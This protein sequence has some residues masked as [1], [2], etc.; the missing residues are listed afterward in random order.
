MKKSKSII[1]IAT[2]IA[3][4]IFTLVGCD[5]ETVPVN[6]GQDA[7]VAVFKNGSIDY[8]RQIATTVTSECE[9]R[10]VKPIISYVNDD[11]DA[12]GQF[13]I[14]SGLREL[15]SYYNI[16]GVIIAPVFTK[17]DHRVEKAL[18][19]FAGNDIPVIVIDS[20]IDNDASPLK[21]T[22]KAYV[23]T[24]NA[25]AGAQLANAC[26]VTDASSILAARVAASIPT[27]ARYEGFCKEIGATVPLWETVDLDT[28]ESFSAELAKHPGATNLVFFNGNLCNSVK[29]A[30][31]GVD[32]YTFDVYEQ[33]LLDLKN[34][35]TS[36][37]KGIMAQNTFEMGRQAVTAIFSTTAEKNIYIPTIYIT[38]DNLYSSDVKPFLDY[39]NIREDAK[40]SV[41]MLLGDGNT[42]YWPQI[43]EGAKKEAEVLGVDV[44][45]EFRAAETD[46]QN[47]LKRIDEAGS[48]RNL[49]GIVLA[50]CDIEIDERLASKGL[51]IPIVAIDATPMINSP[52]KDIFAAC[53]VPDNFS[54]GKELAAK[55]AGSKSIV[56]SYAIGGSSDRADGV[57]IGKGAE[58]VQVFKCNTVASAVENLKSCLESNPS[59]YESLILTSGNFVTSEL[60]DIASEAG[61]SVCCVDMNPTIEGYLQSGD[62]LFSAVPDT[63]E[64]G[65][66]AIK[67]I[68]NDKSGYHIHNVTVNYSYPVPEAVDLGLSV[69]WASFNLGATKP[70]GYGDYYAWG[71]TET[72]YEGFAQSG[73]PV[74]KAG[75]DS[76]YDWTTC[77]YCTDGVGEQFSKYVPAGEPSYWGGSGS[78]DNK[79]VL[80]LSDDAAHVKLGGSWRMPTV[81]E[82]I[83]LCEPT[84]CSWEWTV[85]NGINGYKVTS[86]KAGFTDKWIFLPASGCWEQTALE[87]LGVGGIYWCSSVSEI[88]PFG[89]EILYFDYYEVEAHRYAGDRFNGSPIR[90]V[91]K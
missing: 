25:A 29:A 81:E 71:A 6:P 47:L 58:N 36:P 84:N 23:G 11:S 14:V 57:I 39:Y 72:W 53:V 70:E 17:D 83:E 15:K 65:T 42:L 27:G 77:P 38:S 1:S 5:K 63:Y 34:P 61:L 69:K 18:A 33:F 52:L 45:Y 60:M 9:A 24:D 2:A 89:G 21:D 54:L 79:T 44:L 19:D 37:I 90:P 48:I 87:S 50:E 85:I 82:Y 78:P 3:A 20:P 7:V 41:L 10:G 22:Y 49:K 40:G 76:G 32:V 75:K 51:D 31:D 55:T 28:P 46:Y 74:W 4:A 59:V 13:A 30:F 91:T 67:C 64:I 73:N 56:I 43:L 12:D 26:G 80:D 16:K 88:C 62:L 86:L 68:M 8:W 35:A 66:E